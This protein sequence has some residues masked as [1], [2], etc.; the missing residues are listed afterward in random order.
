MKKIAIIGR[1]NVGKSSLFN[2]LVK[3][4]DAITSDIA[5]TTR[6]VKRR[7]VTIIN[8]QALLLDTGGLD[9]GCELFDRIKEKSLEAAKKADI[10]L[11]MVDGKTIPEDADK[12]L[13]YELQ[14]LGKDVALVVNKIDNDKMKDNLWDY[15]EFGT[16]AIFGISV[17]HNRSVVPLLEWIYDR[18]PECDIIKEENEDEEEDDVNIVE[19]DGS[20][21]DFFDQDEEN[22]D[23]DDGF[24]YTDVNEEEFEDDSIFA[25]NDKI[26]E[27][28]EDDVNH[29]KISIIGRTNVG[30]SSLLN[31][32]LGEER[33]VVSSVAGTTIDPID[34]SIE[35]KGKQLTF[36]DT[37]GLRRRG[38]IVGIEK[39][40]LMRTKEMLENSNMALVVLD[41]SEPLLDLDEKIAG[42]VDSN[43]LA[44]IIVL[45]KWDIANREDYDKI[46]ENVR[47][48]FKFLAYAPIITLSAKSHKR[49]DK[50]YDMI[51]EINENYSQR[52]PTS[53]LN[54]VLEKAL[55]KH[56]LPSMRGQVIRI[57]YATQY[58]T[59]PPKI[60]IVMNKPRGLHFTYRRYLT[61]KLREAFNFSGTPVL[62]KAKKRGEK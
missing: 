59:R 12:K 26:K 21:F 16:D 53:Q 34:E 49:V 58:E 5:G 51:L 40:A 48:R 41:G 18:I 54:E 43:R 57:Y 62:F 32:L 10:I 22:D 9:Q 3:K 35:Y 61:N 28:N 33:S 27:F 55:R 56:Q 38:K 8:K 39:F 36:V 44:C 13:F 1:P 50:L 60:A 23:E 2:R 52:I 4:R 45:N 11:Y 29:I 37:A 15:Y 25:Q 19:E 46:I 42:L 7:H 14:T 47:D 30:K 17:S 20:E 24:F 31:A 6:D